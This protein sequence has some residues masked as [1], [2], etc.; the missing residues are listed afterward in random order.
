MANARIEFKIGNIEFVSE[1]EQE[2]VTDQLDKMLE[3]LPNLEAEGKKMPVKQVT[4]PV[5]ASVQPTENTD[6]FT[7][8][9][10]NRAIRKFLGTA[11]WLQ[12]NGQ[13]TIKTKE[14]TD[15][16]RSAR[17]VKITNPSHQLNQNIAQGF[18]QKEGRGFYVTPQGIENIM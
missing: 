17:Q 12:S 3:R 13:Q 8:Q 9:K 16:L 6:L 7:S 15:A 11:V 14:V 18:C 2:W 1:G 4:Q 5:V 10:T